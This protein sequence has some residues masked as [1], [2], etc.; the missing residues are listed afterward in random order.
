[1]RRFFYVP[2][3]VALTATLLAQTP[4]APSLDTKHAQDPASAPCTVAGRV[5]TAAD[6][7]PVKS[8]RIGLI[9]E[10]N[11]A[12][13]Q[14]YGGSSDSDGN[15]TI[16]NIPPGPYQFFASHS[17]FVEQHYKAGLNESWPIFSLSPG[18]KVADVVFRLTAAAVITGRITNEDGDPMQ[19]V[20]VVA[21]RRPTEDER[22]DSELRHHKVEMHPVASAQSDDRGHYRIFGL[23]PGEYYVRADDSSQPPPGPIPVEESFW[24][25]QSLGSDYAPVYYPSATSVS[26]AQVIPIK[27]GEEAQADLVLRQVKTVEVSGRVIGPTGPA[28][29]ALVFLEPDPPDSDLQRQDTTDEKGGFH[30]HSVPE[31]GYYITVHQ[32]QQG[33][34]VYTARAR[35]KIDVIGEN[36]DSLTITLG[37]GVTIQGR[38]KIDGVSSSVL[39]RVSFALAPVDEDGPFGGDAEMNKDGSFEMKSVLD[40]NYALSVWGLNRGG[41]LKSVHLGADNVLEKG[42]QVEGSVPGKIEVVV[43][44]DGAKVEGS[45]TDDDGP[46]I[47]ARIR[48]LPDPLTPYN[49]LRIHRTSTDQLGH[50]SIQ[51]I[52]PGKYKLTA[53]PRAS[54][55][56]NRYKSDPQELKVSENDH[57]TIDVKFVKQQE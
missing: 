53:K 9:P 39:D 24:V 43:A 52:A 49:H 1:M 54:S 51:D 33:T 7:T 47:G 12:S 50:F 15:F 13:S 6:G 10:N 19:R 38:V 11:R 25:K 56:T 23:K 36:I 45:V 48:L 37:L 55:E 26:Q 14:I 35:Q 42:V 46:V 17:G 41:Y 16:K 4:A 28:A 18:E 2:S 40:G 5:L 27:S 34:Y 31:G 8:A 32:R 3:V 29:N 30:L 21:L 44:S 20:E 22:E 57:R